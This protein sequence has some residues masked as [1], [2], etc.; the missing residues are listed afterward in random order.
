ML[1]YIPKQFFFSPYVNKQR[2]Q[3]PIPVQDGRQNLPSRDF[4]GILENIEMLFFQD[5]CQHA[6]CMKEE[7]RK[8]A[9]RELTQFQGS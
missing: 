8:K 6:G 3:S 5:F 4:L 7:E 9:G 1:W 2:R